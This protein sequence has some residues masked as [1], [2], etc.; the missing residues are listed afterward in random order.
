MNEQLIRQL[1][2]R[3]L[4]QMGGEAQQFD[5]MMVAQMQGQQM[6]SQQPQIGMGGFMRPQMPQGGLG[7]MQ[8]RISPQR[9]II[10]GS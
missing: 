6:L 2:S 7:T 9:G 5:P 8:G 10:R 4:S 1:M 3:Y